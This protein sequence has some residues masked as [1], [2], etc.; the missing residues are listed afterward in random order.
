MEIYETSGNNSLRLS[1]I[2]YDL[3]TRGQ[4]EVKLLG[5]AKS[6]MRKLLINSVDSICPGERCGIGSWVFS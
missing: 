4:E 3:Y 1:V 5:G 2:I 6:P